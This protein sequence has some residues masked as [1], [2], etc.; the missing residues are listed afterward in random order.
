MKR[1]QE[2]GRVIVGGKCVQ[3][4]KRQPGNG[5]ALNLLGKRRKKPTPRTEALGGAAHRGVRFAAK[6]THFW[7]SETLHHA[8]YQ[9][10]RLI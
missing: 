5:Q 7:K 6:T 9:R 4:L 8:R 10:D 1:P 2:P 3:T